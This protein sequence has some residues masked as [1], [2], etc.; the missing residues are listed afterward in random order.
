MLWKRDITDISNF[1]QL[2]GGF[3]I[4]RPLPLFLRKCCQS[5]REMVKINGWDVAYSN[6]EYLSFLSIFY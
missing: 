4:R 1:M 2:I 5:E 3:D 6:H